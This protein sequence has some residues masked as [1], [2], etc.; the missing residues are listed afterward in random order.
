MSSFHALI[1]NEGAGG[2]RVRRW[3]CVSFP[4]LNIDQSGLEPGGTPSLHRDPKSRHSSLLPCFFHIVEDAWRNFPECYAAIKGPQQKERCVACPF[5]S[6][7]FLILP[8]RRGRADSEM[9]LTN[10]KQRR[11]ASRHCG[12]DALLLAAEPSCVCGNAVCTWMCRGG[13]TAGRRGI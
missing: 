9:H 3:T 5:M 13:L 8:G 2:R 4:L 1:S 10:K 12:R 6:H 11:Y 7:E